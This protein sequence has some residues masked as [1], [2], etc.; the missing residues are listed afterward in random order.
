MSAVPLGS[1]TRLVIFESA[2]SD[3]MTTGATVG[4]EEIGATESL[5]MPLNFLMT[6]A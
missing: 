4:M 2:E 3:L 6:L 5:P 1:A